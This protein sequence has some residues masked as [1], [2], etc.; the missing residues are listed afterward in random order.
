MKAI[1]TVLL[2]ACLVSAA[3]A[4]IVGVVDA[5]RGTM[6]ELHDT[7]GQCVSGALQAIYRQ[8][9]PSQVSIPGCWVM[10]P[11]AINVVFFDAD[12]ARIPVSAVR[13]PV[14]T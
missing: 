10:V 1:Q 4:E 6:I 14:T 3:H 11:G 5:G 13:K 7:A 8:A 2:A 9:L 12:G